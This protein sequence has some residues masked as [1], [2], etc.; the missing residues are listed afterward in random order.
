MNLLIS[1]GAGMIGAALGSGSMEKYQE[2]SKPFL[3]PPGW[4]FPVVWTILYL[5]MGIAAYLV[6]V[7]EDPDKRQALILYGAQLLVNMLWPLFFFRL[8]AYL[9][10]FVWLLLLIDLVVLTAKSFSNIDGTAG[11][12]FLPYLIWL[13]FA[14]YLNLAYL[15]QGLWRR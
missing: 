7:S 4:V 11:K 15:L 6:S 14:A 9:L 3:S 8:N 12:L 5:L 13:V 2:L 1:L 10:A